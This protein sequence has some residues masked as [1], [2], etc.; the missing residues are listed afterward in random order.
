MTPARSCP[1]GSAVIE[2]ARD[3][4]VEI[5]PDK[6]DASVRR[7]TRTSGAAQECAPPS[8]AAPVDDSR[9]ALRQRRRSVALD[10]DDVTLLEQARN[11]CV[12]T[13]SG[14]GRAA[15]PCSDSFVAHDRERLD[16]PIAVKSSVVERGGPC[17]ARRRDGPTM[18]EF[19]WEGTIRTR[20][21]CN[22]REGNDSDASRPVPT[23]W[24]VT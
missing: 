13:P 20:P 23:P 8:S 14:P 16:P 2:P 7:L 17:L 9:R 19:S 24:I 15:A 18:N 4:R 21:L 1:A 6:S 11:E 12:E 3:E 5:A 22:H 10:H